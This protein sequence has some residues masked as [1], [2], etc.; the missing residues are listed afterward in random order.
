MAEKVHWGP[1]CLLLCIFSTAATSWY[2]AHWHGTSTVT[3]NHEGHSRWEI[4]LKER[5]EMSIGKHPQN[6]QSDGCSFGNNLVKLTPFFFSHIGHFGLSPSPQKLQVCQLLLAQTGAGCFSPTGIPCDC[7]PVACM[8]HM[9]M[10]KHPGVS[11]HLTTMLTTMVSAEF[12][13]LL[14]VPHT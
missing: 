9:L 7:V 8:A 3:S 1:V 13:A 5:K 4:V 10:G 6:R 2:P 12:S 14:G 11:V